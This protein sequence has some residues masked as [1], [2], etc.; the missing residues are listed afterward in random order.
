MSK[1]DYTKFTKTNDEHGKVQ[2]TPTNYIFEDSNDIG[3]SEKSTR[4]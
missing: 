3:I 4:M 2:Q 1:K